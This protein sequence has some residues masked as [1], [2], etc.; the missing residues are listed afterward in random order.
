MNDSIAQLWEWIKKHKYMFVTIMIAIIIV[1]LDEN[2][3]MKHI[4]NTR[5]IAALEAEKKE[6]QEKYDELTNNLDELVADPVLIEK[7]ARQRYGMH[8]PNE[9]IFIFDD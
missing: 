2:N 8:K 5:E 6:L 9:E 1:F 4:Q 3:F 7:I